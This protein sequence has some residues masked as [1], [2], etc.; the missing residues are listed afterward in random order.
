MSEADRSGRDGADG[1]SSF[2]VLRNIFARLLRRRGDAS[3]AEAI[4]ELIEEG[5]VEEPEE[6]ISAEERILLLNILKLRG[7]TADDVM[8]P[9]ADIVAAPIDISMDGL[10][11]LLV[12]EGHS[13]LPVYRETLDSRFA[14]SPSRSPGC[15]ARCC[16]SRPPRGSW[17]SFSKCA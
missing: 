3:L 17:I 8:V 2:R 12:E 1:S 13:R 15:C 10:V 5:E 6:P 9:R 7:R 16:S 4:E 14:S 11:K